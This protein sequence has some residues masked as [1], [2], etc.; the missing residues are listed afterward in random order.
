[1]S[2]SMLDE[3]QNLKIKT[4]LGSVFVQGS[5]ILDDIFLCCDLIPK[6][7]GFYIHFLER[8][9]KENIF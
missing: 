1:V 5:K 2:I 3:K 7:E 9:N 6:K 8:Y 4:L